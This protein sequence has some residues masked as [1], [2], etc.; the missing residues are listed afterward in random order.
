MTDGCCARQRSKRSLKE[1]YSRGGCLDLVRSLNTCVGQ[2]RMSAQPA[3]R[4]QRTII[5]KSL[6]SPLLLHFSINLASNF[7]S[8][9]LAFFCICRS[10]KNG[11]KWVT[12][13]FE[14][15]TTSIFQV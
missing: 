1:Q 2:S 9:F 11:K 7:G 6:N 5:S 13:G 10:K 4:C 15:A 3:D 8:V 12:A 14:L